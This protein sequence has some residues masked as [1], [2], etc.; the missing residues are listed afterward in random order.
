MK[1]GN[2]RIPDG[3]RETV[4]ALERAGYEAY[5]VGGCVRDMLLGAETHDWDICTNAEP[6]EIRR[7]LA[8]WRT[9]DTGARH[10]TVTALAPDGAYEVTTYRVDGTY[11]DGRHPDSVTFTGSLTADLARRDFTINAMA[12]PPGEPGEPLEIVDPFGGREDLR[13]RV[14]RCVGEPERRFREDALRILRAI[15]FASRL[16]L[17]IEPATGAAM[18]A[19][20]GLLRRIS[21]ERIFSELSG[22][23]LTERGWEY[24]REYRDVLAVVVPELEPCFDFA[25]DNPWH[26]HDVF[27]HTVRSVGC[28]PRELT[29]RLTMLLHDV[30]KPACATR[31]E[32]GVGHFYG[33]PER[34]AKL[35]EDVLTRLRCPNRL[36]RDVTE[37]VRV[38]DLAVEPTERSIRRLLNRLG[39]EQARRLMQVKRADTLAQSD[40][41]KARKLDGL[42]R[43]EELLEKVIAGRQAFALKDLAISGDDLLAAGVAPG[44]AL[45]RRLQR[46]LDAVLDGTVPNERKALLAAALAPEGTET[47]GG[48][49]SE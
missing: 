5:L 22:I 2:A 47:P 49:T 1:D 16:E 39:E 38:H 40:M 31:D 26:S 42:A 9:L 43:C 14:L 6:A 36:I 18:L 13:R 48:E 37:L 29:L 24:L 3:A 15:R 17:T 11:S 41:A 44:P 12:L 23:L 34:S 21:A 33:H 27:E 30:G 32:N 7:A 20:R 28:A 35:A 8:P 19:E 46:V 25:Q 4:R 45:G 10:G